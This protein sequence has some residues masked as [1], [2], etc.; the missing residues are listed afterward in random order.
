MAVEISEVG[1]AD[2]ADLLPLVVAYCEFYE[3]SPGADSLM[4]LSRALLEDT[5]REGL[6]LIAREGYPGHAVGF[7]TLFWTWSTLRAARI[8]VMNDLYVAEDARGSGVGEALVEACRTRC[9]ERGMAR[10]EWRTAPDN[11]RAQ[12]LY[13]RLGAERGEWI[14]Y[15]LDP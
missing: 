14:D 2:L 4:S 3:V 9:R 13:D 11:R 7:A 15:G 5:E 1:E 6:Q 8:G 10:L 12:A